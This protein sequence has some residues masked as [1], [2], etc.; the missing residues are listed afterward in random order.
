[1]D[2]L[3]F[4]LRSQFCNDWPKFKIFIDQQQQIDYQCS[5][6]FTEIKLKIPDNEGPHSI[7]LH[8]YGKDHQHMIFQ[9]NT[10]VQDQVLEIVEI[11]INNVQVPDYVLDKHTEFTFQDQVHT[12]SRYFGPNGIWRWKYSGSLVTWCLDQK[13]LHEAQYSQDY[14]LPWSYVLGPD[15]VNKITTEISDLLEKLESTK[16]DA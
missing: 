11:Y 12:G 13:I 3:T 7:E 8:R 5:D 4:K 15:S 10:V 6:E 1:M 14:E 2:T 9:D 16:F